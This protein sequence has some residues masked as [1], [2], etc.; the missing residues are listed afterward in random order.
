L[1]QRYPLLWVDMKVSRQEAETA[2]AFEDLF[3]VHH[4]TAL[5]SLDSEIASVGPFTICF[6]FDFPTKPGLQ[7]LKQTKH[8][9]PR[10]PIL[11]LTV[12]HSEALAVWAFRSKVWDYM[13]KPIATHELERCL[14]G[15]REMLGMQAL[16]EQGRQPAMVKS[17]IPDEN[18]VRGPRGNSPLTLAPAIEYV[19]RSYREKISSAKAGQL[20]G[21]STFQLSRLFK[22][23]YGLTFQDY[24]LRFRIREACRLLKN[25]AAEIADVAYLAGFNDPS[26][27][28][29]IFRRY[30]QCSPSEFHAANQDELERDLLLELPPLETSQTDG[31]KK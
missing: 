15:L 4:Y 13:V 5:A 6:D 26:Y 30:M 24:V 1:S 27:F 22:E 23:T 11:M 29:K 18:R 17:L 7:T 19:E 21:I 16:Q 12:Q 25:P 10:I 3:E 28:G 2:S 14:V 31:A 8:D 20:C 9:H